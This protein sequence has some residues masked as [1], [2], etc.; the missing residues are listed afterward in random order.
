[1]ICLSENQNSFSYFNEFKFVIHGGSLWFQICQKERK[2][3]HTCKKGG[4][5]LIISFWHLLMYLKNSYLLKKLLGNKKRKNFNIYNVVIFF[6]FE[7]KRKTPGDIIILHL[8]TKN[9]ND[10]IYSSWDKECDRLAV[11]GCFLPFNP[12]KNLKNL[13]FEKNDTNA[14]RYYH[15]THVYHKWQS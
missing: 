11:L 6:F 15:F 9:L 5:H 4:A 3:L 10:I 13:N 7:K 8:C 14:R 2:K 12:L 1:M